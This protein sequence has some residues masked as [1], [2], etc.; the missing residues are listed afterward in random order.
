MSREG[1]SKP[2]LVGELA[3]DGPELAASA[4]VSLYRHWVNAGRE[5]ERLSR[6]ITHRRFDEGLRSLKRACAWIRIA[7]EL[8]ALIAPNPADQAGVHSSAELLRRHLLMEVRPWLEAAR[9]EL[10]AAAMTLCAF[11][12]DDPDA[13]A[14]VAAALRQLDEEHVAAPDPAKRKAGS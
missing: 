12:E 8:V 3:E 14:A 7:E 4:T 6:C 1:W 2:R 5:L 10:P 9:E 11:V 13:Q